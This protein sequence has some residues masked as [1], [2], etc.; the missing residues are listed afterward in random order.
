MRPER[1]LVP[2][3]KAHLEE[4]TF[5]TEEKVLRYQ[6]SEKA[7]RKSS[8]KKNEQEESVHSFQTLLDDLG[9]ICLNTVEAVV[10]GKKIVFEKITQPTSLQQKALALLGVRVICTQ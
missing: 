3:R 9:T 1:N 6:P 7:K 4:E 2:H 8:R 5:L 10:A